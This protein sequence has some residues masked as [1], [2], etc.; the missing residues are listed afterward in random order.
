MIQFDS[1]IAAIF[2]SIL[3]INNLFVEEKGD[4]F[5]RFKLRIIEMAKRSHVFIGTGAMP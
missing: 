2:R 5:F 3:Q 1:K 4:Y